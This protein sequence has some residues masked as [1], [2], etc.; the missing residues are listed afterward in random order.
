MQGLIDIL[1][2]RIVWA[3]DLRDKTESG[4]QERVWKLLAHPVGGGEG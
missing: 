2:R 3:I 4:E 1:L